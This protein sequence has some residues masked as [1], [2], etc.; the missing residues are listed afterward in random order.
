MNRDGIIIVPDGKDRQWLRGNG[1]AEPSDEALALLGS[2]VG[3]KKRWTTS[4]KTT[5]SHGLDQV[6]VEH[7]IYELLHAG[8]VE[9]H[10]R[11]N[12]RGDFEP[13]EWQLTDTGVERVGVL[14]RE[15]ALTAQI[16]EY[17]RRG[18]ED[19]DHPLLGA[20]HLWFGIQKQ[21]DYRAARILM[22]IGEELRAGRI[23]AERTVSLLAL[24]NTKTIRV[25][26]YPEQVEEALG[27][28]PDQV[29]R[30]AGQA[31]YVY[32]PFEFE[33]HGRHIDGEWSVPWIALTS[34][35]IDAI[36]KI[37]VAA[38]CLLTIENLTAFEEEVRAGLPQRTIAVYTGGFPG[39][40]ENRVIELLIEG[41]IQRI[42]HWSDLDVGGLRIYR[43]LQKTLP[44][45]VEPFRMEPELLDT[46]I[47]TPLTEYDREAL[48]AWLE[49]DQAPFRELAAA[50]LEKNRKAE[51]ESWFV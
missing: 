39:T 29:V 34:E 8:L 18:N 51:Q 7:L 9:V 12:R 21:V 24:G 17:T 13:Y 35:S 47:S 1:G 50:M 11:R 20:I 40:L 3:K 32:G 25:K 45:T 5:G 4:S 31:V 42:S 6:D 28:P 44:V 30:R 15:A 23:P 27:I 38:D 19:K 14:I 33:I 41:G 16:R 43:Y 10:T 48:K 49:D 37:E 36:S 22:S 46:L 26:N 2:A